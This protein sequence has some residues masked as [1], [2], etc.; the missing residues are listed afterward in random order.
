[1][2]FVRGHI[3]NRKLNLKLFR[4]VLRTN[5]DAK[6]ISQHLHLHLMVRKKAFGYTSLPTHSLNKRIVSSTGNTFGLG[7]WWTQTS[8]VRCFPWLT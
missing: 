7:R 1:V 4:C 8:L 3:W 2:Q 5:L 6:N